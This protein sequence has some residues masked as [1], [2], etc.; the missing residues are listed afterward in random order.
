MILD[1][2]ALTMHQACPSKYDLRIKKDWQSRR[3]SGALNGGAV[4]HEGLAAWHRGL[5]FSGAVAA[6]NEAWKDNSPIDDWRTKEKCISTMLEYAKRYPSEAFKVIGAPLDPIIEVHFTLDTGLRMAICP[7]CHHDHYAGQPVTDDR[8]VSCT[9]DLEPLQYGGIFDGLVEFSGSY[10]ILEHKTASQMGK[11]FFSQFKPNNQ[12]SGYIW[13]AQQLSGQP[14]GGAIINAIGWYRKSPTKFERQIV[15]RSTYD[16][17][18]WLSDVWHEAQEI[19]RHELYNQFPKRTQACTLYGKCEFHDLHCISNPHDQ[20]KLLEQD[21]VK[22]KW[23]FMRRDE[24]ST[25]E[26]T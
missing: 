23:D 7:V 8:C 1:N 12:V 6:I 18:S 9:G 2:F 19:R 11:Y 4:I 10:Y 21:F 14:V 22:S 16:I 13:A 24:P 15:T 5:G 20:A 26:E 3:V 17:T 25:V